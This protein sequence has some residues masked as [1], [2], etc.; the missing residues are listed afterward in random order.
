M[1]LYAPKRLLA[2]GYV[3]VLISLSVRAAD[4]EKPVP[5]TPETI[6]DLQINLTKALQER[7]WKT[8]KMA[9]TGLKAANLPAKDLEIAILRSETDA[10][11]KASQQEQCLVPWGL[12]ARVKC[13]DDAALEQLRALAGSALPSDVPP[14]LQL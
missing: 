9:A 4:P 2:L 7:N 14:N 11:Q 8:L 3:T 5:T 10:A 13:G 12:L 1:K 6:K